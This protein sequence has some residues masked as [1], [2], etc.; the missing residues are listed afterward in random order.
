MSEQTY[1]MYVS[2][3]HQQVSGDPYASPWEYKIEVT[4]EAF[5]IF[6]QLFTQIDHLEFRNFLRAHLPYIQYHYDRD[7]HDID[8]RM[9]KVYALIHE[10]TDEDSKRFIEKLPFFR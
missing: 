8:R 4:K 3:A 2:V 1:T 5:P 6:E 7:N 9:M 10:Y